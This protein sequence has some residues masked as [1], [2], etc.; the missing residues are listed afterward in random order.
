MGEK[1]SNSGLREFV[2]RTRIMEMFHWDYLTFLKQPSYIV[3]NLKRYLAAQS[4]F[5]TKKNGNVK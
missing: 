5:E 4:E 1:T 3:E 2:N